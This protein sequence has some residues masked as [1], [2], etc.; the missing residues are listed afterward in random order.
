MKNIF[1]S[2]LFAC[3]LLYLHTPAGAVDELYIITTRDGSTIV[4]RDYRFTDEYVEFTTENGLPGYIKREEFVKIANMVGVPPGE[5]ERI[6]IQLSK[7]ERNK[8]LWLL[9]SV[10][11]AVLFAILLVY[12]S[13]RKKKD[14]RM[15]ADIF[16]ERKEKDSVTQGHLSFEYK[17]SLGR[18]SK[19]TIEVRSAYEEEGILFIEGFCTATDKRKKFRADRVIGPVTDMSND[20]HAPMEHFF[21]D[22]KE[23]SD[24]L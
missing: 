9:S 1:L 14:S 18:T 17:G 19:W 8:E 23:E 13:G 4:A 22:A 20:H 15:E 10:V 3:S 7:N 12:L 24:T 21:V 5:T 11:L 16:Y 6:N 2:L